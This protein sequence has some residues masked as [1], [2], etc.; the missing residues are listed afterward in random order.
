MNRCLL[1]L[2][3]FL[4]LP[5]AAEAQS[6]AQMIERALAAAPARARDDAVIVHRIKI[7]EG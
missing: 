6:A 4:T 3:A 5:V 1:L 7:I 2:S